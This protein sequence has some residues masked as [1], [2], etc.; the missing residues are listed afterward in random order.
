MSFGKG[1][2]SAVQ[3]TELDNIFMQKFNSAN[4]PGLAT[5]NTAAIFN[6]LT[7]D[8]GAVISEVFKGSGLWTA[9]AEEQDVAQGTPRV[10]NKITFIPVDY[11]KSVEV[12]RTFYNDAKHDAI[13]K[14]VQDMG[15]KGQITRDKEAMKLL[16]NAFTTTLTADGVALCSASHTAISGDTISNL[17]TS[18]ALS[19]T[20]LNNAIVA[21]MELKD[22]DGVIRGTTPR[23]LL[24][25]PALFKYAKELTGSELAVD[26][27]NN[28]L[29]VF[30]GVYGIEVYTSP[31]L[32]AAAGGS[33]TSWFLFG[34]N[35]A[36]NRYVR[37]GLWTTLVDWKSQRNNNYI[38]KGG[39]R[40]VIGSIDYVDLIGNQA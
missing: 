5:A 14:M 19:P 34:Y 27:A 10:A 7:M 29:N 6:Q 39:F 4:I 22:Q 13:A 15:L 31:Y 38:Y 2:N 11:E 8:S 3:Q 20:T 12:P 1:L 25:P 23:A 18:A 24:V 30:R 40:E 33:D 28:N 32:G 16:I 35:H 17:K 9:K 37:E 26:T 21:L 36:V